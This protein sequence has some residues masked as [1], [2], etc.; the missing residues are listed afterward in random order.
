MTSHM[1]YIKLHKV[2][3]VQTVAVC[4]WI[5]QFYSTKTRD[6]FCELADNVL[7]VNVNKTSQYILT[8]CL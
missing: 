8:Y 4:A 6:Y 2:V 3:I 1:D 5:F 7:K